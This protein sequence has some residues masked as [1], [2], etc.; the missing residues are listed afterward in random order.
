MAEAKRKKP[1]TV[2]PEPT[3]MMS[4]RVPVSL[5]ARLE[6]YRAD[7]RR[8]GKKLTVQDCVNEALAEYLKKR[9]V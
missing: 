2:E 5:R 7:Q 8:V 9:S 1:P 4:V 3:E 6:S